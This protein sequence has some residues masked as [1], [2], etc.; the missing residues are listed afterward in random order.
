VG[1]FSL[2]RIVELRDEEEATEIIVGGADV[3]M[4]AN[5]EDSELDSIM[6][7]LREHW[8]GEGKTFLVEESGGMYD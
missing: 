6:S 3:V 2:R 5:I 1:R 7:G 8:M 4:L